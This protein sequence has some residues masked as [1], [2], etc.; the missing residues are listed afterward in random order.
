ML[1]MGTLA[2][3][4]AVALASVGTRFSSVCDV[5]WWAYPCPKS[6]LVDQHIPLLWAA[7]PCVAPFHGLGTASA[8]P[9]LAACFPMRNWIDSS[10]VQVILTPSVV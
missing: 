1:C 5:A 2:R 7:T 8:S 6:L 9:L 4:L 10:W 3:E